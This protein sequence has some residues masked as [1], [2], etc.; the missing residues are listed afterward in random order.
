[1]LRRWF[2]VCAC[3]LCVL[4]LSA[5]AHPVG[6]RA[7]T[8]VSLEDES[9]RELRVYHHKGKTYALGTYGERYN[10]RVRNQTGRRVEA[11]V[12]VDG[13]DVISG[14]QGGYGERGYLIEAYGTLLIEGFR[15]SD[16]EVAA[17][18]FTSPGNSY[19]ARMGTPENVGVI[20]VA[21][22][23]E[24]QHRVVHRPRRR[25]RRGYSGGGAPAPSAS[26]E[27]STRGRSARSAPAYDDA[28]SGSLDAE[29][30]DEGNN[31]GTEYGEATYSAVR[32][33]SFTRANPSHP[34]EVIVLHYDDAAGLA[35]RGIRLH[36]PR[37][38][39][40]P[41]PDAFPLSRYAPPPP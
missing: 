33:V 11:V 10:I 12:T 35:R 41:T 27:K 28:L 34:S 23:P 38:R 31:I 4:P 14:R 8:V 24:R 18:R 1:M 39:P 3:A 16:S 20:G 13:R 36:T 17:F 9:G 37:P 19:S 29:S 40:R 26:A 21:V 7:S 5:S 30:A 15:T 32:N 22:F 2:L 6:S 25:A